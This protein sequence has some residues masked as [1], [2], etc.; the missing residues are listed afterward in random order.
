MQALAF[1]RP[2]KAKVWIMRSWIVSWSAGEQG[3]RGRTKILLSGCQQNVM[4][5][6][7]EVTRIVEGE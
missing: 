2:D 5:T 4:E 6:P 7:E 1:T 3:E